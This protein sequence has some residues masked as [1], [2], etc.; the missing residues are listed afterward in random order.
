MCLNPNP[1]ERPCPYEILYKLQHFNRK[2]FPNVDETKLINYIINVSD[3]TFLNI[4]NIHYIHDNHYQILE[5]NYMYEYEN[6]PF[7]INQIGTF[8]QK[9]GCQFEP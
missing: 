2:L 3:D 6:D 1:S 4:R 7:I 8:R 9:E 5:S